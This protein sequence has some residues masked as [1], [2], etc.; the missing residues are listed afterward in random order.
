RGCARTASPARHRCASVQG[1]GCATAAR[2]V[3]CRSTPANARGRAGAGGTGAG[4]S[5][6]CRLWRVGRF[7]PMRPILRGPPLPVRVR[8]VLRLLYT[9][10]MYLLTP[11]ILYRLAARGIKYRRYLSRWKERYGFFPDPA[12]QDSIWVHAV[13]VGEVN[14]S[15]PLVEALMLRYP[16]ARMVVTTVTPTGS[17]RVQTL[18]GERVFHVYLPYD[19][20]ASV[21][22]FLDRIRPRMAVILETEIWPNLYFECDARKSPLVIVNGRLSERSRRGYRPV[23]S[24][25]RSALRRAHEVAAQSHADARRFEVLGAE[26]A[27]VTIAGNLKFDMSVSAHWL[28]QGLAM[29]KAWGLARPVWIAA[30]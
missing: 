3:R 18:F 29:R 5:S 10:T 4:R 14:A 17:E 11:V 19:L 13:S 27:R 15:V 26:P 25:A 30:S 9:L 12:M 22:R 28:T 21:R 16:E 8:S 2:S 23:W 6:S 24:L 1:R 7:L 20:P